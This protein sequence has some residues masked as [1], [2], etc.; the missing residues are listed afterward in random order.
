MAS[1]STGFSK[2]L[3]QDAMCVVNKKGLMLSKTVTS[4]VPIMVKRMM[5]AIVATIGPM[6]FSANAD[7]QIDKEETVNNARKATRNPAP[8]RHIISCSCRMVRPSLLSTIRD[9]TFV[10]GLKVKNPKVFSVKS[11]DHAPMHF[12]V[13]LQ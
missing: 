2:K 8:N 3:L 13:A 12:E 6:E 7:R 11:S 4:S 1:M 9:F 5:I 10:R